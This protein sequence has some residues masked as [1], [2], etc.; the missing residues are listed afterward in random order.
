MDALLESG[1]VLMLDPVST[2]TGGAGSGSASGAPRTWNSSD[3]VEKWKDMQ[4]SLLVKT[5]FL[6]RRAGAG[7]AINPICKIGDEDF[8]CPRAFEYSQ[9]HQKP[10]I[11]GPET[12]EH[13][14]NMDLLMGGEV[15][16]DSA[17]DYQ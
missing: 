3:L 9:S 13:D 15:S 4:D 5:G 10:I 16:S 12:F 14:S 17:V 2:C 11:V 8:I 7:P 6:A 1:E